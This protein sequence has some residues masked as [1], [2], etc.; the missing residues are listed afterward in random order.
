MLVTPSTPPALGSRY[1]ALDTAR[2]LFAGVAGPRD[3]R[4]D[5]VAAA[6]N[7]RHLPGAWGEPVSV[8]LPDA[9]IL[10]P[11]IGL[12]ATGA[13][14]GVILTA[15]C[16][17]GARHERL[18]ASR[19]AP[20][21]RPLDPAAAEVT[22]DIADAVG[23][24][25]AGWA[26]THV[27]CASFDEQ[28]ASCLADRMGPDLTS[29]AAQIA[30]KR[31]DDVIRGEAPRLRL[32]V[33]MPSGTGYDVLDYVLHTSRR[34]KHTK[35]SFTLGE[36][37]FGLREVARQRRV[38]PAAA[39][40]FAPDGAWDAGDEG[41]ASV[42]SFGASD[43]AAS[44]VDGAGVSANMFFATRACTAGVALVAGS[45]GGRVSVAA[46]PLPVETAPECTPLTGLLARAVR[47]G[48]LSRPERFGPNPLRA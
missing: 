5:A 43:D 33:V 7:I 26:R 18:V 11:H 34:P 6:E 45:V 13:P 16:H 24:L 48:R 12:L 37:Q 19:F 3:G 41:H 8:R 22:H 42:A 46:A 36:A 20:A 32:G 9:P 47:P 25:A 23:R 14:E 44:A 29:I 2:S 17:C 4:L 38:Q 28:P 40:F 30:A 27:D 15:V 10:P 1:F 39:F 35:S 21:V 31:L